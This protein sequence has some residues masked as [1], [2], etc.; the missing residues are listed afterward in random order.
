MAVGWDIAIVDI[1][2]IIWEIRPSYQIKTHNR[3]NP[4]T[5]CKR[6]Y[7]SSISDGNSSQ[8]RAPFLEQF[9]RPVT[10]VVR[11]IGTGL[12]GFVSAIS[13]VCFWKY[14]SIT[15]WKRSK[16]SQFSLNLDNFQCTR[17]TVGFVQFRSRRVKLL[18]DDDDNIRIITDS[19]DWNDILDSFEEEEE[20]EE[21][22]T[23]I[24]L[25]GAYRDYLMSHPWHVPFEIWDEYAERRFLVPEFVITFK[26]WLFSFLATIL[27]ASL[28]GFLLT[29]SLPL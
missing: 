16:S 20:E 2:S 3:D 13:I 4:P 22:E 29:E 11:I 27:I 7:C 26:S 9:P 6:Q 21:D 25:P 15:R 5:N 1:C 14:A 17:T 10:L 19:H 28:S 8:P 12:F 23:P 24:A 18:Q